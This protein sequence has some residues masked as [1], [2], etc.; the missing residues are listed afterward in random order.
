MKEKNVESSMFFDS[1]QSLSHKKK[2][3]FEYGSISQDL[4]N[5][6]GF[7]GSVL[8]G[9]LNIDHLLDHPKAATVYKE[10]PKTFFVKRDFSLIL[11]KSVS[12]ASIQKIVKD[13]ERNLLKDMNLF[14]VYE[15]KNLPE[16]KKS[17]A[18]SFIFQDPKETLQDAQIDK[19][20]E[21]IRLKL[22]SEL[23]AELRA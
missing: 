7:K 23:G 8:A 14:D 18:V 13:S 19:V 9:I 11:D 17:Y 4:N 6:I 3:I 10:L 1:A 20:M 21:K 12:Y 22:K 5:K 2:V 15:G 16:D